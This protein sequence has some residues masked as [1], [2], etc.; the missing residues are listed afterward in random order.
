[1]DTLRYVICDVFTDRGL[2]GNQL[3]VFTNAT[4][5]DGATMQALAREMNFSESTFVLRPEQGGD[6]KIRIFTPVREIPFA[7]HPTLGTAVVLGGA[8]QTDRVRLETGSGI[9]P[10]QLEREGARIVFGRMEQPLPSITTLADD[11]SRE[12]CA[13]L[14]IER[15]RLPVEV[16]DN[17]I[18]HAFV[19]LPS[20]E[21]VSAVRP[22][23]E[24]LARLTCTDTVSTIAGSGSE[25]KTRVFAP[26]AGVPEDAA[27]GSAA[28]ALVVHLARH[29]LLAF[30]AE[31]RIEQGAE[32]GRP[33]VLYAHA[34]G[35]ANALE[36]VDVGGPAVVVARGEFLLSAIR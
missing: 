14:R 30:G 3:A 28:G 34:I 23:Y 15:S 22:D 29:G 6:A 32:L 26:G 9:V 8:L 11:D 31:L 35:S 18:R 19:A 20:R 21:E 1:L 2:S 17:G 25:Y 10:V 24:R 5:L 33:S 16:Y 13:A 36:R 4:K 12:L 7:G 27:T